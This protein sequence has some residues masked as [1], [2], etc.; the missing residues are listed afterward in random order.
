VLAQAPQRRRRAGSGELILVVE[1]NEYVRSIMTSTLRSAGY[2]V[3]QAA[4]GNEGMAAFARHQDQARL[5]LMDVDLPGRDGLT[6]LREIRSAG[7][8]IPVIVITG[9][10]DVDPETQ[11]SGDEFLLRKP[12]QM[13]DVLDLVAR[14]LARRDGMRARESVESDPRNSSSGR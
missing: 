1:D 8:E 9:S 3:V 14:M 2:Q 7:S 5:I 6:C 11:F 4:D 10:V 12:F 13:S